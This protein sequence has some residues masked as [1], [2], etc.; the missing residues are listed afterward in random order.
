MGFSRQ[1][2]GYTFLGLRPLFVEANHIKLA[3]LIGTSKRSS[4]RTSAKDSAGTN[5][6]PNTPIR[7]PLILVVIKNSPRFTPSI[8]ID[9]ILLADCAVPLL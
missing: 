6:L 3:N 1:Q 8:V 9:A 7:N 4:M 2:Q 5:P